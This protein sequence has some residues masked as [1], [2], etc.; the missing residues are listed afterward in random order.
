MSGPIPPPRPPEL[1]ALLRRMHLPYMRRA[2]PEVWA[3][4]KAQR[5][6]PAEVLKARRSPVVNAQPW[7]PAVHRPRFQPA[8]RS[9]PGIQ[10]SHRSP[11]RPRRRCAHWN[12]SVVGRASSFMAS[13]PTLAS[14]QARLG[15]RAPRPPR[16][17][18]QAR[19]AATRRS[20]RSNARR[21]INCLGISVI[22]HAPTEVDTSRVSWRRRR[23]LFADLPSWF[24]VLPG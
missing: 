23:A 16:H 9:P 8:R 21:S 4:A 17:I 24:A 14:S 19:A 20:S 18:R 12:G 6:D 13:V 7:A 10:I 3:T 2:G 15:P 11:L 22:A 5:W 1:E